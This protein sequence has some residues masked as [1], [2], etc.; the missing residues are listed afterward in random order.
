[1]KNNL[2]VLEKGRIGNL[3]VKNR[4]LMSS[5]VTNYCNEDGTPTERFTAYHER[6][7]RG[8]IGLVTVEASYVTLAGRGFPNQAGLH[9][10]RNIPAWA[11][12]TKRIHNAGGKVSVQ[13]YHGGRQ[14]NAEATGGIL[15]APSAIPCPLMGG[16][17]T[18]ITIERIREIIKEFG[19]AARRAKEAGF[20]AVE[21]HGAHGYLINEFESAYS[22]K[23]TDEY[24]GSMENR[25]R[26]PLEVLRS[27]REAVGPDFPVIYKISAVEGVERG[28]TIDESCIFAKELVENGVSAILTSRAVYENVQMQIPPATEASA[29]NLENAAI[30]KKAVGGAVPV[31]VVGRIRDLDVIEDALNEG[32]VDFVTFARPLLCDPDFP[33]KIAEGRYDDIRRCLSCNQGCADILLAGVPITCM[34]NP[35]TG[36]EYENLIRRTEQPK[37]IL[38]VGGGAGGLEAARVAALRGHQVTLVEKAD[39]LGGKMR[40][41]AVPPHKDEIFNYIRFQE[42]E[43]IKAGV[44]IITGKPMS[45]EDIRE[46]NADEVII[47]IGSNDI[48]LCIPGADGKNVYPYH[49]VLPG[50]EISGHSV[51]VI[52]GGLVGCETAEYLSDQGKDITIVEMKPAIAADMGL[53]NRMSMMEH[54]FARDN[55]KAMTDS[56]LKSIDEHSIIFEKD[57]ADVKVDG[58]DAVVMAVGSR[59]DRSLTDTLDQMGIKYHAVGECVRAPGQIMT[60]VK[61][62]FDLACTL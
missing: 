58:I 35:E 18:A 1:M 52:G 32:K 47:A 37:N 7:A 24:G 27:V 11:D 60:A 34:L 61:E 55:F 19:D 12:F 15:E 41:A 21:I 20:D 50:K 25:H 2:K 54:Y 62:A 13:L 49:E 53:L 16:R 8:G 48:V 26:F 39:E 10:D 4:M 28:L 22:N 17:P 30:I 31:S 46:F 43:L 59:A 56:S 36:H 40:D 44:D 6:R 23:R 45:A 9:Q 3:E 5:M 38:V 14:A 57:G 29:L 51:A 33:A 42:K